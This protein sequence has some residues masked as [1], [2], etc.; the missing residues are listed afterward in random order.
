MYMYFPY[1]YAS[2]YRQGVA[3]PVFAVTIW[4]ALLDMAAALFV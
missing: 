1:I 4:S 2:R 3:A